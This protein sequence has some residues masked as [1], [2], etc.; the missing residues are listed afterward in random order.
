ME[1]RGGVASMYHLIP[2]GSVDRY[3]AALE[4]A[5]REAGLRVLVSGPWPPYAFGD[6]W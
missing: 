1:K 2:S 5:A 6:T 4:H 3:R